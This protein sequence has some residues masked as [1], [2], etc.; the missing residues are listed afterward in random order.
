M[1]ARTIDLAFGALIEA[2]L[3]RKAKTARQVG[4]PFL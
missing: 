4:A 2:G 3:F 1:R